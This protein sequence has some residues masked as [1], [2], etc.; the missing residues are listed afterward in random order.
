MKTQEKRGAANGIS[1]TAM[2]LFKAIGPAAGGS[3][4]VIISNEFIFYF[5]ICRVLFFCCLTSKLF[6]EPSA[7]FLTT[8]AVVDASKVDFRLINPIVM[9]CK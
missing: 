2:S 8:V 4:Y 1:M 6:S 3:L 5:F 9:S 7:L